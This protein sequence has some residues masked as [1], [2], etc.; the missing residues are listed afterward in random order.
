MDTKTKRPPQKGRPWSALESLQRANVDSAQL[1]AVLGIGLGFEG[2]LLAFCQGLEAVDLDSREVYENVFASFIVGNEAVTLV[3]V[4]PF[5]STVVHEYGTSIIIIIFQ[6]AK[7][8]L[9]LTVN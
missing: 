6:V 3:C 4:E 8:N 9:L 5:Y 1:A 7:K 2:N